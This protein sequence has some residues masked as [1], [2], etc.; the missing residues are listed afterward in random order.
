MLR[1]RPLRKGYGW[2]RN[3]PPAALGKKKLVGGPSVQ[4]CESHYCFFEFCW[5]QFMMILLLPQKT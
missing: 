2:C 4:K 1:F 5:D 3:M